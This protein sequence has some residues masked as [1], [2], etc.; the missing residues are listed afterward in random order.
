MREESLD[1]FLVAYGISL[2]REIDLLI[3]VNVLAS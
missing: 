1:P 2:V 3:K